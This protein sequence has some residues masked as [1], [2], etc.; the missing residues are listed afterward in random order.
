[1]DN[2]Q[3]AFKNINAPSYLESRQKPQVGHPHYLHLSDLLMALESVASDKQGKWLDYGSGASPY[4]HLFSRCDYLRADIRGENL[5]Y[6]IRPGEPLNAPPESFDGILSTQVLEHVLEPASYL[7]DCWRMLKPGGRLILTT[8][9]I[10]KEHGAPY[11]Y[12][13]WTEWGLKAAVQGTGFEYLQLARVTCGPRVLITLL[14]APELIPHL[15]RGGLR[16]KLL[17]LCLGWLACKRTTLHSI[18]DKIHADYRVVWDKQ[19]AYYLVL[20]V[21]AQKPHNSA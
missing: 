13:R 16:G 14:Q 4:Q 21:T 10:W 6:I 15:G 2:Q 17:D 8:H 9:G 20:L 11:D 19:E 18:S 7:Q 1:M 12:Y 3:T 5:D